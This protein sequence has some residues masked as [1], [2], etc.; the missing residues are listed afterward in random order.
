MSKKDS[1]VKIHAHDEVSQS[2]ALKYL[3]SFT[4]ASGLTPFVLLQM[5][6]NQPIRVEYEIDDLGYIR[7]YLAPKIEEDDDF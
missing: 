4:K 2:F 7:Y 6:P 5:N 3:V 1:Y